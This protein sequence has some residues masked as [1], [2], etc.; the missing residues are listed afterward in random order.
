M[1]VQY[2]QFLRTYQNGHKN[3]RTS[4][5]QTQEYVCEYN[6]AV[7]KDSSAE[8]V[9]I[10]GH[11]TMIHIEHCQDSTFNLLATSLNGDIK[12]YS[13]HKQEVTWKIKDSLRLAVT[14]R[15]AFHSVTLANCSDVNLSFVGNWTPLFVFNCTSLLIRVSNVPSLGGNREYTV[16]FLILGSFLEGRHKLVK[17]SASACFLEHDKGCRKEIP[18]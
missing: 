12:V 5:T 13:N 10:V 2:P 17:G 3:P 16:R 18:N 4:P 11:T 9:N 1:H 6:S 8:V 15:P 7:L 14:I